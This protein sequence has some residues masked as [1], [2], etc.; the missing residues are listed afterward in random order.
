MGKFIKRVLK[1]WFINPFTIWI[2][3]ILLVIYTIGLYT[4]IG[5]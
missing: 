5:M 2:L 3:L 4:I 1:K